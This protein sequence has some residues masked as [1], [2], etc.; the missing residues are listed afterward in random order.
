MLETGW[1]PAAGWP[2][3]IL[4]CQQLLTCDREAVWPDSHMAAGEADEHL[5]SPV[6]VLPLLTFG[7]TE[8]QGRRVSCQASHSARGEG[9]RPRES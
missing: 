8:A 6:L 2:G 7:V 5:K 4:S 1:A 9:E 3:L